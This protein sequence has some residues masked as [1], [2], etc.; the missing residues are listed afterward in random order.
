MAERDE[1]G[2]S[3]DSG[4][5]ESMPQLQ[6]EVTCALQMMNY[7]NSITLVFF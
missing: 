5:K 2:T 1:A 4:D 6:I 3:T 7:E